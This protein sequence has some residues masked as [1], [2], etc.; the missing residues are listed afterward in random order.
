[1]ETRN[2]HYTTEFKAQ[3]L[4]EVEDTGNMAAVAKAHGISTSTLYGWVLTTRTKK[5]KAGNESVQSLSKK[6]ANAELE[7]LVLKELLKKTNQAWLKG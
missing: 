7:I 2:K 1:M 3:L 4:K 6:L 5:S